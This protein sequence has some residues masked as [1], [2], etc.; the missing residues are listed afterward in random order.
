M[1]Y[2]SALTKRILAGRMLGRGKSPRE[3]SEPQRTRGREMP[4]L[5]ALFFMVVFYLLTRDLAVSIVIPI[6]M[7]LFLRYKG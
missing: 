5:Y 6:A 4:F 2:G 7:W 3:G 1:S